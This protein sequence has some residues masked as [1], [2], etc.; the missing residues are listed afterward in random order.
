MTSTL[1]GSIT[2]SLDSDKEWSQ[3]ADVLT[4]LRPNLDRNQFVADRHRLTAEGYRLIA[5]KM[6]GA[7]VAI[8]SYVI[9]PHPVYYRELQI[10]DMAT[11]RPYQ[12]KGFGSMLLA[13]LEKIAK[14]SNCGRCYVNSRADRTAAH[15]FYEKNG[16]ESYSTGFVKKVTP[17]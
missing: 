9:T 6:D 13:E 17:I 3:A 5:V 14:D 1:K 2:R 10:H 12:S 7:I 4:A 15:R 11:S 16:Y 8:V